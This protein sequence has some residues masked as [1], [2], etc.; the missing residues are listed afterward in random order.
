[1]YADDFKECL[2]VGGLLNDIDKCDTMVD[3]LDECDALADDLKECFRRVRWH[4]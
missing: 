2:G 1:M 3:C 4:V